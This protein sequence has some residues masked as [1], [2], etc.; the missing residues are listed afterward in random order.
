M[1]C[2]NYLYNQPSMGFKNYE[3]LGTIHAISPWCVLLW[4][5]LLRDYHQ[6]HR[7]CFLS[8]PTPQYAPVIHQQPFSMP[9]IDHFVDF[10]CSDGKSRHLMGCYSICTNNVKDIR[11]LSIIT[12]LTSNYKIIAR[13][14]FFNLPVQRF[15]KYLH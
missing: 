3:Y 11:F 7:R 13:P 6:Y 10:L 1:L 5:R 12:I 8:N 9:Y 4:H 14:L 15:W 2:R